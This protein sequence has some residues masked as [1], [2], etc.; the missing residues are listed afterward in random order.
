M[1]NVRKNYEF[2]WA[3]AKDD[4]N[5]SGIQTDWQ[6]DSCVRIDHQA[7]IAYTRYGDIKAE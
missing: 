2:D 1:P 6:T 5:I 4:A 3:C 7:A